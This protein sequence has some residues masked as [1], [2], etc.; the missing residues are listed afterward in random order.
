MA[1]Y[2]IVAYQFWRHD[3][4]LKA[5]V[6]G[7]VP[8]RSAAEQRRWSMV[9]EGFTVFNPLTNEFGT[10]RKPFATYQL[11]QAFVD[12]HRPPSVGIGS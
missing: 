3:G 12:T 6:H 1:K 8:W 4:G 10:G 9:T 7:A 2:E 11:A 5:S